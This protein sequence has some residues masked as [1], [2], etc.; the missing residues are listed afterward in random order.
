MNVD[1]PMSTSDMPKYLL[2]QISQTR[3]WSLQKKA[4]LR[5]NKRNWIVQHKI[6]WIWDNKNQTE[7]QFLVLILVIFLRTFFGLVKFVFLAFWL[8]VM[9]LLYWRR[10][11][12]HSTGNNLV[13]VGCFV[14]VLT[15]GS[16]WIV[17]CIHCVAFNIFDY[18]HY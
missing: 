9:N 6:G 2:Y 18:G 14:P 13:S 16:R 12:S 1:C 15:S 4:V 11:R 7:V 10:D 5:K 17:Y 3:K 8:K